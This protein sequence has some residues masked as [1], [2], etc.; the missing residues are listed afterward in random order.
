M[1]K[2]RALFTVPISIVLIA[3]IVTSFFLLNLKP[4]TSNISEAQTLSEYSK[5]AVVRIIDYAIVEW[6]FNDYYE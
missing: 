6:Q 1:L 2:K 3:V 5:P 4:D